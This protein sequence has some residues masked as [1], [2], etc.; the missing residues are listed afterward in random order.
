MSNS[1]SSGS[2][3]TPRIG[4]D[5]DLETAILQ[6][7][8]QRLEDQRACLVGTRQRVGGLA[9]L[10]REIEQ[11]DDED[12]QEADHHV[13]HGDEIALLFLLAA[14]ATD[15]PADHGLSPSSDES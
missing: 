10:Q 5:R 9:E 2:R 11:Q 12:E 15:T 13:G 6:L 7:L 3:N 14:A 4:V 1:T 8:L